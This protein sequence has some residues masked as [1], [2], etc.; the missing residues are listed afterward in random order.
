[1][2]RGFIFDLD[3]VLV[4]T[5]D[6]HYASW[7][8]LS[9]QLGFKLD[10]KIKEKLKGISRM[11]SLNLVLQQGGIK[12]SRKKKEELTA[13]K[14]KWYLESLSELTNEILL[15]GVEAFVESSHKLGLRLAIGSASKNARSIID[16]T[17]LKN[18]FE[19]I[20]DGNDIVKTKP[21]PEVF[22]K[23]AHLLGLKP[24]ECLVFEDSAKGLMAAS[25]GGF[26]KLGIGS[27]THLDEAEVI[28]TDLENISASQICRL[29][30]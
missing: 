12:L 19:V 24:Q 14:N 20:V 7:E 26:R 13:L 6:Y 30:N 25:S 9:L 29:Y 3:G 21:D 15:P 11:D 4:D 16:R 17:N 8:R 28:M 18:S 1:M 5:V 2:I 27:A 10:P 22:L 23:G